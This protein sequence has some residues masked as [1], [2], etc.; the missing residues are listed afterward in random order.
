M[1]VSD[2]ADHFREHELNDESSRSWST[3]VTYQI[4]LEKW[5]QPRWGTQYLT[6]V[7]T[8]PVEDWL[9]S[10]KVQVRRTKDAAKETKPMADGTKAKIRNLMSVLFNHAIRWEFL[11]PSTNPIKLVRQSAKRQRTPEVLT[12][13]EI[14]ALLKKLPQPCYR[15]MVFLAA[16][17]GLRKSEFRGLKW[18]DVDFANRCILVTRGLVRRS[19]G[20]LK[21]ETSQK[22]IPMSE[23]L[24][25]VLLDWWR[26][27][28]YPSADDWV[29]AS[30]VNNGKW[31]LW[32]DTAMSDHVRPAAASAGITKG[33]GWHTFRRSF[34]TVLKSNG[35]DVKTVQ[36]LMRH[37]NSRV[38]LDVYAQGISDVKR[39]A[40][41]RVAGMIAGLPVAPQVGTA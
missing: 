39:L 25:D 38:T 34:A 3:R 41:S 8:M 28:P 2:L 35:E 15:T 26:T 17:T 13:E 21:T 29:F 10:L 23:Q 16:A 9:R 24:A 33:V 40:Q 31:P 6:D 18:R 22:P 5:I 30:P 12:V 7:R 1:T 19:L 32:P 27:S 37:A 36:E 14:S 4:Y 20:S 11:E